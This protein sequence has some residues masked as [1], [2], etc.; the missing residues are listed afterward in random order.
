[1]EGAITGPG[2]QAAKGAG[3]EGQ[4]GFQGLLGS[5]LGDPPGSAYF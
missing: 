5:L 2:L 4:G 1:M 3:W